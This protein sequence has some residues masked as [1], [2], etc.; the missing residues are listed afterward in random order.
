[1]TEETKSKMVISLC[2][3]SFMSNA[4]FSQMSPFYPLKAKEK[5]VTAVYVGFVFGTMAVAQMIS[6]FMVGKCM[7]NFGSVRHVVIMIGTLLIIMQTAGLGYLD[8]VDD[9]KMF[10]KIS[11]VS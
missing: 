9:E 8:N 5:G 1:M 4:S 11:F 2:L 6:S 3:I 7:H 10:L